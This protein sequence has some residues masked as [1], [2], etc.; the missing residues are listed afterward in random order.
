MFR[1][2]TDIWE[3]MRGCNFDSL[4]KMAML[5]LCF[6]S[7]MLC[8]F[9]LFYNFVLFNWGIHFWGFSRSNGVGEKGLLR[10]HL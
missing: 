7:L 9:D 4:G 2:K 1:F 3:S 8:M 6:S 5:L 10:I